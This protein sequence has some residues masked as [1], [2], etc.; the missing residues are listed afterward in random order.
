MRNE[1]DGCGAETGSSDAGFDRTGESVELVEEAS[2]EV[3]TVEEERAA[4]SKTGA[5]T[6]G[7]DGSQ[8]V[9]TG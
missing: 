9:V 1:S 3:V 5:D 6:E 8:L 4:S 2:E 7:G